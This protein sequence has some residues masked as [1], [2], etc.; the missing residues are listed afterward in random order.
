MNLLFHLPA[1]V[2]ISFLLSSLQIFVTSYEE[3]IIIINIRRVAYSIVAVTLIKMLIRI[4]D[5]RR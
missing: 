1:Y 2:V 5:K 3:I 4:P